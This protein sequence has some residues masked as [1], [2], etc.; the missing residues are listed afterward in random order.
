MV[1]DYSIAYF[2]MDILHYM[3]FIPSE[4]IFIAHHL[5]TLYLLLTCRYVVC[6]G[7][8]AILAVLI[9]AE[10][11]SPCQN[12]WSLA[13]LRKG[14]SLGANKVYESLSPIFFTYYSMVKM[15]LGS[16]LVY[17]IAVFFMSGEGDNVIRKRMQKEPKKL[18]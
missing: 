10:I 8:V 13:R 6:H 9:L 7:A 2:I 18:S 3:L 15:V 12:S 5:A 1:L 4:I 11:T 16:I 14:D 17:K